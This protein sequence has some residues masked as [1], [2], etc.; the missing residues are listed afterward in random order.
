MLHKLNCALQINTLSCRFFWV[1]CVYGR[2]N[3]AERFGFFCHAALEF[4]LQNG[5]NPVRNT[6][7]LV[8]IKS[9]TFYF[10]EESINSLAFTIHFL[11]LTWVKHKC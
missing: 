3:D 1:G 9:F 2:A 11:S 10:F 7:S 6:V 8:V 5:F 4:L